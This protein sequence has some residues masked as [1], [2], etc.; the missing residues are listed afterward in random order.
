M[1]SRRDSF[2]SVSSD[3]SSSSRVSFCDDVSTKSIEP[4]EKELAWYSSHELNA[5]RRDAS[6]VVSAMRSK[7]I[8]RDTETACTHGLNAQVNKRRT[9][10][11]KEDALF[12]V[13]KEQ[14]YQLQ[15]SRNVDQEL[16]A[17]VYFQATRGNQISALRRGHKH[18]KA[19][20]DM[21]T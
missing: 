17:E 13:L 7:A 2:K 3:G 4:L 18:A 14:H 15:E 6:V 8:V 11:R 16:I 12:A 10:A 20:Q 19:V 1:M 9:K 21:W 5:I